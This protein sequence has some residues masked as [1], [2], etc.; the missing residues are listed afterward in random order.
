MTLWDRFR[1]LDSR[2]L[3]FSGILLV[4]GLVMLMSATAA[5]SAKIGG[6]PFY[7]VEHQILSGVL[8]GLVLFLIF[9]LTD[10]RHW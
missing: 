9:G 6:G 2:V 8:P 4:A 7:F 1:T 10:Y 5:T 3:I